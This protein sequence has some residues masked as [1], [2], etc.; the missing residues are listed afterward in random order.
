MV[1]KNVTMDDMKH[2]GKKKLKETFLKNGFGLLRFTDKAIGVSKVMAVT[3]SDANCPPFSE[4]SDFF[5]PSNNQYYQE[6]CCSFYNAFLKHIEFCTEHG[7][8]SDTTVKNGEALVMDI[9]DMVQEKRKEQK[10]SLKAKPTGHSMD[11]GIS[12]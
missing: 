1:L 6:A 9:S 12:W 8:A 3:M 7:L 5:G 10:L 4:S 2:F 11:E